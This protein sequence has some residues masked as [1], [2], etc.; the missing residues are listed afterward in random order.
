MFA[1]FSFSAEKPLV[2]ER[3]FVGPVSCVPRLASLLSARCVPDPGHPVNRIRSI[4]FDT[5]DLSA[6]AEKANGDALKRKIRIRWYDDDRDENGKTRVYLEVKYRLWSARRKTRVDSV[7]PSEW[8]RGVPLSDP[9]LPEFLARHAA[10]LGEPA[11]GW[12]PVCCIGY[13]RMRFVDPAGGSRVSLDW[14]I[15]AERVNLVRF[16]WADPVSLDFAVCEFKN[17]GGAPPE[18]AECAVDAGMKL[19]SFSKYGETMQRIVE[20]KT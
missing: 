20:A 14:N 19:R 18:W 15:R 5:P 16:P 10:A 8:I 2:N 17:P 12:S 6:W 3:K 1:G 9:S 13:D 11:S 4:Y 7:A